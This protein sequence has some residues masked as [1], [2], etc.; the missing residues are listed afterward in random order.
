MTGRRGKGWLK[1]KEWESK[2]VSVCN[3]GEMRT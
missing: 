3:G 2:K 1:E